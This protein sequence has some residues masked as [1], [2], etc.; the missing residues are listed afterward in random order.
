[1]KQNFPI[2]RAG[3]WVRL[4]PEMTGKWYLGA[5]RHT[6]PQEREAWYDQLAERCLAGLDDPYDSAGES[7]LAPLD[8]RVE[9]HADRVYEVVRGRVKA[10]H[11]YSDIPGCCLI[12][13]LL[14]G[15]EMF[16]RRQQ[17]HLA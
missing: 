17:L 11:G 10:S 9:V 16:I 3:Q 8:A 7:K 14:T 6:T 13:C 5:W 4:N 2:F 12:R 1:M 15:E